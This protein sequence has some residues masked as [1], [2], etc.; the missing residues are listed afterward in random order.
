[1]TIWLR[2]GFEYGAWSMVS[3]YLVFLWL[4]L[5]WCG[6]GRSGLDLD[7]SLPPY[8]MPVLCTL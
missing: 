6:W 2:R 4:T 3:L 8:D 7:L 5:N 1:M